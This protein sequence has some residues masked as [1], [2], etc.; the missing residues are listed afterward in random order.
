[1]LSEVW[2]TSSI[3]R[4]VS[5]ICLLVSWQI[6]FN[7]TTPNSRNVPAVVQCGW[8]NCEGLRLKEQVTVV[9]KREKRK[10]HHVPSN[11]IISTLFVRFVS[12]NS[13]KSKVNSFVESCT[14]GR[15]D[16][17]EGG[18]GVEL[19]ISLGWGEFV[20]VAVVVV[21]GFGVVRPQVEVLLPYR[22]FWDS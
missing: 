4:S 8:F 15:S 17:D 14:C 20:V 13:T 1:M 11:S 2:R 7:S 6:F 3:I 5:I 9:Q 18:V 10:Q 19:E 22:R 16:E 12:I 21:G